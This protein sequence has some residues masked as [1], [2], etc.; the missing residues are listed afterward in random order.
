M[1]EDSDQQLVEG[2]FHKPIERLATSFDPGA[3]Q[4]AL[5]RI[6]QKGRQFARFG[7]ARDL[8]FCLCLGDGRFDVL[9][10]LPVQLAKAFPDRLALIGQFRA[11]AAE[12]AVPREMRIRE[13]PGDPVEMTPQTLQWWHAGI[14]QNLSSRLIGTVALDDLEAERLLAF[15]IVVERTLRHPRGVGDVLHADGV[16]A[17][18]NQALEAC[19]NDL[20]AGVRSRHR[21]SNMTGHLKKQEGGADKHLHAARRSAA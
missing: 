12:N 7:F 20:F 18:L 3:E 8:T 6:E 9:R 11:E 13:Q 2:E 21:F 16:E 15:E 17:P 19:L 14:G 10:P 4:G 5:I 1:I